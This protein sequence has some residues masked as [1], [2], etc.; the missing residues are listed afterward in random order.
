MNSRFISRIELSFWNF[1]IHTLSE[2]SMA[3]KMLEKASQ[4]RT[5]V[6]TSFGLLLGV[7]GLAGLASGY[8]FYVL[9]IGLR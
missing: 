9:T 1:A 4:A 7:S 6:P 5:L 3:R 8:T 2:F